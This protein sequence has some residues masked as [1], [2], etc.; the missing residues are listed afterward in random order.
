VA[1]L[2]V[3]VQM[4]MQELQ[5]PYLDQQEWQSEKKWRCSMRSPQMQMQMQ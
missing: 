2:Q 3:L 4:Q 1:V 5:G